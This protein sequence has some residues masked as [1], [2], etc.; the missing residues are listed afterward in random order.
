MLPKNVLY[1]G[2]DQP[3]PAQQSLRAGPLALV[4]EAGDL[5]YIKLGDRG[6]V[7]RLYVA[8]RDRNWETIAP[9]ISNLM[10]D[11]GEDAFRITYDVE[12]RHGEIDFFWRGTI[13]GDDNWIGDERL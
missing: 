1:Y 6:I 11:I 10:M 7:R 4:Y 9:A 12:N 5:R 8:V 3:L 2:K 13:S